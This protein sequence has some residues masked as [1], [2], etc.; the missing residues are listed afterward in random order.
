M[1]VHTAYCTLHTT[2]Y[3][4][5]MSHCA[6]QTTNCT[7][8]MAQFIMYSCSAHRTAHYFT[9]SIVASLLLV[10]WVHSQAAAWAF[11]PPT[12]CN[13]CSYF[14]SWKS[15]LILLCIT[16]C[17]SCSSFCSW[18]SWLILLCICSCNPCNW[19]QFLPPG[20]QLK[21]LLC[22]HKLWGF[23]I[24]PFIWEKLN[25]NRHSNDTKYC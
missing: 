8:Y 25:N 24:Y 11:L 20:C 16:S 17:N 14:S 21:V 3:T 12:Y 19:S 10:C 23:Q 18:K 13:S 6:L 15:W 4:L 2:H 1:C 7:L 9:N 22:H 5:H